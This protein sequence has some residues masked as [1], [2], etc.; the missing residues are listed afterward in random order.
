LYGLLGVRLMRQGNQAVVHSVQRDGLAH[1]FIHP[2]DVLESIDGNFLHTMSDVDVVGRL[3]DRESEINLVWRRCSDN[4][5]WSMPLPPILPEAAPNE[6][7]KRRQ[8]QENG[9]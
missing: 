8:I 6:G 2:G 9:N 1:R 5:V 7:R 3:S 4:L